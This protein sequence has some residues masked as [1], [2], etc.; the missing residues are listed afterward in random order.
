MS[1]KDQTDTTTISLWNPSAAVGWSLL[2]S[3]IFGAWLHSKNWSALGDDG[4]A[5]QSMNW[6]YGAIVIIILA[7]LLPEKI[8]SAI[9]LGYLLSWYFSSAQQQV[10]YVREKHNNAYRKNGW[11]KPIGIAVVSLNSFILVAGIA[12]TYFD[13]DLQQEVALT[14]VSGVWRANQDG[15]M[16]TLK[17][18]GKIKTID[19]NGQEIPVEVQGFDYENKILS[20]VVNNNPSIIWSVRQIFYKDGTFILSLTL[21]DG[22]QDDLSFVRNL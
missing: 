12:T 19:I 2:F 16:V 20:L 18:D 8:G 13:S 5:K 7:I 17:L 4:K 6:V 21:H 1:I 22:T 14:D 3:P 9:G 15:T 11:A 10:K